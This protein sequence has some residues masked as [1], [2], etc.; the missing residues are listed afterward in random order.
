MIQTRL[1]GALALAGTLLSSNAYAEVEIGT[2]TCE[3]TDV[4]NVIIY[5]NEDF[6]CIFEPDS[7]PAETYTG[8]IDNIGINLEVKQD[9]TIVW[10]VIAPT[11]NIYQ[12]GLLRGTYVGAGAEVAL[13]AGMGAK[14]LVG[15]GEDSFTLQPISVSGIVG[16]G[17]SVGIESFELR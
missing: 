16:G 17:A 11:D 3:L 14:V 6:A 15:G 4:T 13:G 5:K 1:I 9:M 12:P 8:E 2:L 10:G 7:G